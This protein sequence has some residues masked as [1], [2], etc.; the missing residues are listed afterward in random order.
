LLQKGNIA[1][2]DRPGMK[3]ATEEFG[4]GD[5]AAAEEEIWRGGGAR[6][7]MQIKKSEGI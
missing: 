7:A 5:I 6:E 4:A 2:I 1:G 3:F